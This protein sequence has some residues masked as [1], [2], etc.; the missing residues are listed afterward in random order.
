[1]AKSKTKQAKRLSPAAGIGLVLMA[2]L[3]AFNGYTLAK[4]IKE[5]TKE[6]LYA[7]ENFYFESD[8]LKEASSDADIPSYTLQDG[9]TII[10]FTLKNYP[11]ELRT[12]E[13]DITYTA[14]LY[15]D[16]ETD[17]AD[18][19]T[20]T[21]NGLAKNDA[22]VEFDI[23]ASDSSTTYLVEVTAAPYETTL[24]GKFVIPPKS[25][26][27][28]FS[29]SDAPG[30]AVLRLTVTTGNYAGNATIYWPQEVL[31]DNTDPLMTDATGSSHTVRFEK[32]YSEY[33][34]IF[35]K[36]NPSNNYPTGYTGTFQV[37]AN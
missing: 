5:T 31:P 2:I 21:I 35:F 30:S 27:L 29:V 33:T 18:T 15:K 37:I 19:K 9:S 25:P 24:K 36:T 26:E 32:D 1:M 4:Y 16:G 22:V 28:S 7:A 14:V 11:D 13:L 12:S 3:L 23:P 34:F 20:G 8:L 17:P 6:P 10:S